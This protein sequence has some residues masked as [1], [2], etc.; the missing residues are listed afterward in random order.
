[1]RCDEDVHQIKYGESCLCRRA[2]Q[3]FVQPYPSG[4]AVGDKTVY[5]L[6]TPCS[7]SPT[8]TSSLYNLQLS[9]YQQ[10]KLPNHQPRH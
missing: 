7:L 5:E 9:A 1:M 10:L 3:W 2:P 8:S 4:V 6:L